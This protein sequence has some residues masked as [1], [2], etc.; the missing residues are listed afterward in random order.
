LHLFEDRYPAFDD[1]R[2]ERAMAQMDR[3]YLA[4]DYYRRADY[5]VPLEDGREETETFDTYGWTEH[6]ARKWGQWAASPRELLEQM[7]AC[8]FRIPGSEK[9]EETPPQG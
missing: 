6:M 8:G 2:V 3:G 4:Q 9:V 7:A 1:E 5:M